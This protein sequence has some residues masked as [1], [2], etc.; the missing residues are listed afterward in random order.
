VGRPFK[1][2]LP[3]V[4]APR[5]R[6]ISED[7]GI[8]ARRSKADFLASAEQRDSYRKRNRKPRGA[9]NDQLLKRENVNNQDDSLLGPNDVVRE[10]DLVVQSNDMALMNVQSLESTGALDLSPRYQRR[11]RWDRERQSQLIESFILNVPVPPVY[12]AEEDRGE[13]AVIDGKQRLTAIVQYLSNE[14]EL[15]GLQLRRDL[16]GLTFSQLDPQ[17]SRPLSMRP[18]RTVTIL[19][20]TPDWVKH[21]VFLR[22]NR[23]GQPLNNQEIRNVAF[24]GPL[25]DL[26]IRLAEN[27]FLCKQLKIRNKESSAYT[28]MLDVETV[29]RFFA[30]AGQWTSFGSSFRGGLDRFMLDNYRCGPSAL[31]HY[32]NRFNRAIEACESIWGDLAFKRF[33]GN[34]WR[35]QM[36]GAVYDAQ[37]V[38]ID[39]LSPPEVK[40]L[41]SKSS[42]VI[43]ATETLFSEPEY[44]ASVRIS[45][46]TPSRVRHRVDR[47]ISVLRGL[48][49]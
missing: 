37:M 1:P 24:A 42:A 40:I 22:L 34:Q 14:F 48:I 32:E 4:L 16:E 45:T 7:P 17:F 11:N 18:L 30:I 15:V 49:Q 3:V 46:N 9:D 13:Y 26:F 38:A 29:T 12:L 44:D 41:I 6:L 25:N 28:K 31:D 8:V 2:P 39:T 27:H 10:D 21:E 5:G 20:S 36:L 33:D 19:R 43:E 23:G 35:D 47:T